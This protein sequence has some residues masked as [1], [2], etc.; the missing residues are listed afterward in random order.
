MGKYSTEVRKLALE[1]I[2][3]ITESLGIGPSFGQK[4]G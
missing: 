2:G 1:L 4:Y 3:A